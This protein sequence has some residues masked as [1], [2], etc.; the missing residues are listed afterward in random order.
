MDPLT[1]KVNKSIYFVLKYDCKNTKQK[2]YIFKVN[3]CVSK[4]GK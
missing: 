1:I 2:I 3:G 4:F